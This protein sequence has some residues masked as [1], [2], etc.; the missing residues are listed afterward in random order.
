MLKKLRKMISDKAPSEE[1][2]NQLVTM[3]NRLIDEI[4]NTVGWRGL[5]EAMARLRS[6][7]P[8]WDRLSY[9]YKTNEMYH[10]IVLHIDRTLDGCLPHAPGVQ[11]MLNIRA[12]AA[13]K[14]Y[15]PR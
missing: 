2:D 10:R 12:S 8:Y 9:G 11:K 3:K 5:R 7:S 1:V 6:Y 4:D 15:V 13:I 14:R